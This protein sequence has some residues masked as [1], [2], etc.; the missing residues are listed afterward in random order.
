MSKRNSARLNDGAEP[1]KISKCGNEIS[2]KANEMFEDLAES[3]TK[4]INRTVDNIDVKNKKMN[5]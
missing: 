1:S 3:I 5:M 4:T 2:K